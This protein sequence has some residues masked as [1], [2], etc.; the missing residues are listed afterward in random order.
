MIIQVGSDKT[1]TLDASLKGF[2]RS[3][4]ARILAR[5]ENRLTRVEVHV[6]DINSRKTGPPDKRCLVEAR[7][8]GARPISTSAVA[9]RLD[10][11]IGQ[12]LRKMQRSL[13]TFYGRR[14]R[15]SGHGVPATRRKATTGAASAEQPAAPKTVTARKKAASKPAAAGT[16]RAA[17]DTGTSGAA[18]SG[19]SPKKKDIYQARRKAW[20]AR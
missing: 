10:T 12:A 4:V 5:F 11:A 9:R 20:P 3:E 15:G 2:V 13:T 14:S 8:A 16:S 1:I 7:P 19:R 18:K 17:A 6:S